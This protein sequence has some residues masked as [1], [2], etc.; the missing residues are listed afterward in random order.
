M[1]ANAEIALDHA[2]RRGVMLGIENHDF[3]KNIDYL[4]KVIK[5]IDSDWLGVIWDSANLAP[6]PDPYCDLAR[7]APYA[8]TAQMKVMTRVN[9][10]DNARGFCS[11]D[12]YSARRALQRLPRF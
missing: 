10:E 1:I 8:I 2:E 9:G 11:A 6:T 7:I 5:A 3:V 12:Q 4:L